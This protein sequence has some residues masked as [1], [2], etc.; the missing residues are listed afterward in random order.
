MRG[1][2][3]SRSIGQGSN[4]WNG[5]WRLDYLALAACRIE[6]VRPTRDAIAA[7]SGRRFTQVRAHHPLLRLQ[8]LAHRREV[9]GHDRSVWGQRA[10]LL[11]VHF[12]FLAPSTLRDTA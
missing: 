6:R 1:V 11:V 5:K 7:M 9:L 12:C 8:E 4:R 10:R 2:Q 3:R